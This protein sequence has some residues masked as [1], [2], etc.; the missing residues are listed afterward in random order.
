MPENDLEPSR[1]PDGRSGPHDNWRDSR[2]AAILCTSIQTLHYGII[3]VVLTGWAYD[4]QTWLKGYVSALPVMVLHWRL[5]GN[6]CILTDIEMWLRHKPGTMP[7]KSQH[8]PF[9]SRILRLLLRRPVDLVEA[10]LW[11]YGLVTLMWL[12]GLLRLAQIGGW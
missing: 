4:N 7:P 9:V 3:L 10:N 11:A 12:L 8:E 2:L 6:R 5:N 1:Q